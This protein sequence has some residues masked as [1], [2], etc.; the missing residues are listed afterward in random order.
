MI[1]VLN[2]LGRD[3]KLLKDVIEYLSET[4]IAQ[5]IDEKLNCRG[6]LQIGP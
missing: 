5:N 4:P 2:P 6:H 1:D 3:T